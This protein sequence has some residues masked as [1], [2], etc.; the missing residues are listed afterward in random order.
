[1]P[2]PLQSTAESEASVSFDGSLAPRAT[3]R[4][5]KAGDICGVG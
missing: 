4:K 3:C 5:T 1:L 2:K